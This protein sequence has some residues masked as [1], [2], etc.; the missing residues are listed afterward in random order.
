MAT[1]KRRGRPGSQAGSA[2]EDRE[3]VEIKAGAKK[4]VRLSKPAGAPPGEK[5]GRGRPAPR[6]RRNAGRVA[7]ASRNNAARAEGAERFA[8]LSEGEKAAALRIVT[9]DDRLAGMAQVGRYRVIAAEPLPV[10][11]DHARAEHRLA[12]VVLFDYAS[13]RSVDASVDLDDESMWALS[14]SRTQPGL[15]KAEQ[16]E[17]VAIA[18]ADERVQHALSIGDEAQAALHYWSHRRS[19][20]ARTRRSA[21]VLFGPPGDRPSIVAVVDLM[22]EAVLEVTAASRW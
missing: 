22:E 21:A 14:S 3:D 6:L 20:L 2:G 7:R 17:A 4:T 9:S 15:S 11:R 10:K 19:D 12:R 8:P 1:A 13:E 5:R 18:L 16:S